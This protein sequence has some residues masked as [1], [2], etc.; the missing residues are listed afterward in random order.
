MELK[1]YL[2]LS[3]QLVMTPQLQQAIKLLQLSRVELEQHVQEQMLEN[4]VLEELPPQDPNQDNANNESSAEASTSA[5]ATPEPTPMPEAKADAPD[6]NSD[7]TENWERFVENYQ[8]FSNTSHAPSYRMNDE[9]RPGLEATLA[10]P[11]SLHD[12]LMD[13][14]SEQTFLDEEGVRLA[15]RLIGNIN[16]SGYLSSP[17]VVDQIAED[18]GVDASLVEWVLEHIQRF[19][20]VGVGARDLRECLLVQAEVYFPHEDVLHDV[21]DRH[22]ENLVKRNLPAILRD[23]T[24]VRK[25]DIADAHELLNTLEPKPGRNFSSENAQYITPDV[26]VYKISGE[27]VVVLNEDG[28][29]KLRISNFYKNALQ[30]AEGGKETRNYIQDKFRSAV[31]LIRSIHQRQNTIRK[32]TKSIVKYQKEF[33]DKG[34]EHLRPLIL[35]D[36]ADDIGMHESTVSRV[37]TN[38]YVHTP[39]GIFELKYFFNSRIGSVHGSGDRASEAVKQ[40]IKKLIDEEPPEKPLSD[41]KIVKLLTEQNIEIARRTVAKY[42]EMLKIPSSSQRKRLF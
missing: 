28:L 4:P 41:S 25:E 34:V 42:R 5:E 27:Y 7:P 36:V 10:Q 21:I 24:D 19:E 37:T 33:L 35:R 18:E 16:D 14:L 29:P 32:V 39:Q 40:M 1:Q 2:K 26:Y 11:D 15:T 13:Q 22:L 12:H 20:P 3:Q 17:E 23:L 38:K 8:E 30:Q 6:G 9:E 31:W